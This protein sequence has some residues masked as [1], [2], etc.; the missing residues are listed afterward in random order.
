M[1][2]K[3]L[4]RVLREQPDV[5]VAAEEPETILETAPPEATSPEVASPGSFLPGPV[6]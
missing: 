6:P 3:V 4:R 2:G 5:D 1:I